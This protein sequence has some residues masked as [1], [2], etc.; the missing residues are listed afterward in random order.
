MLEKLM[1]EQLNAGKKTI[2][3]AAAVEQLERNNVGLGSVIWS[4]F[5][6]EIWDIPAKS[7]S[8]IS[9]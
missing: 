9:F 4:S 1:Q 3:T 5:G 8:V 7:K 2:S 6:S